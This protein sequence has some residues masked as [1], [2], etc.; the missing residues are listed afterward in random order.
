MPTRAARFSVVTIA[1]GVIVLGMKYVGYLLTGSIALYSDALESIINVATAVVTLIAVSVSAIPADSNHPYGH[2]KAEYL[3]AVLESTLILVAAFTILREAYE[4]FL[5][6]RPLETP[7]LG[8]AINLAATLIN[9]VWGAMLM[10]YG[11]RWRS[12]ALVADGRHL[13][14][15]VISSVG[16]AAGVALVALTGWLRLDAIVAGLVALHILWSGWRLMRE[17]VGGLMDEALPEEIVAGVR[18]IIRDTATGAMQAN[19]LRSRR[20][21]SRVFIE[22]NLVVPG[23][24]PVAAAHAICDRLEDAIQRYV[25]GSS[26]VIHLEPEQRALASPDVRIS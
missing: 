5:R 18:Q 6:P 16:V 13:W 20:S 7:L 15:D 22:F 17:S 24:M 14:T 23:D 3:S 12:P 4:G 25:E 1:V 8:T 21:G 2:N 26:I 11:R 19:M 10:R 9:G